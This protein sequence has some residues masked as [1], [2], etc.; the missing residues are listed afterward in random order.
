M[1]LSATWSRVPRVRKCAVFS[2]TGAQFSDLGE[3]GPIGSARILNASVGFSDADDRYRLTFHGR[4]L[5]DEPY[6][7]LNTTAG[8]RYH[9]PRDADRYW[10]VSLRAR[11]F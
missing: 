5:G 3:Q 7:L 8:Q 9:I 1:S 6:V 10:G 4:N 11:L 2:F